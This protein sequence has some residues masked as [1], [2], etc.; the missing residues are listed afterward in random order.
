MHAVCV[1]TDGGAAAA[2]GLSWQPVLLPPSH[3]PG[4]CQG[5]LMQQTTK[6]PAK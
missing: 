3:A 5:P 2:P 4:P 1:V 6:E